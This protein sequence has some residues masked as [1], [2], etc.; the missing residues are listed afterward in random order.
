MLFLNNDIECADREIV[1]RMIHQLEVTPEVGVVGCSL[2][3]PTGTIQ[4]LFA[5]PGVKI[6]AAHPLKN[7]PYRSTFTW[8]S[9]PARPVAAVTGAVMMLRATNFMD[10]GMFDEKLPTLGQDVIL[11]LSVAH[12]LKKFNVALTSDSVIH[13]ESKSRKAVFPVSEVDYI[14]EH[15][16]KWLHDCTWFSSEFSRWSERPVKR[17]FL[18]AR[19]PVRRVVSLW[20]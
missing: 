13:H 3:Y 5:A 16:D 14:Y 2:L 19:Y 18:E 12:K 4:H 20:Q 1:T 9:K 11:C 10:A 8:F 17:L 6:I 15:Y 7:T